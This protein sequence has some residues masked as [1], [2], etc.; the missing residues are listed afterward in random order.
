MSSVE[1]SKGLVW[2]LSGTLRRIFEFR[3]DPIR[4]AFRDRDPALV[5]LHGVYQE[6]T[7][8]ISHEPVSVIESE[9]RSA[10]RSG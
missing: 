5:D 1:P 3:R 7:I 2:S 9:E 6:T 4:K 10:R 8:E